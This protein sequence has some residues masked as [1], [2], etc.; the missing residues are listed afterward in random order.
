VLDEMR[1]SALIFVFEH[2]T[3]VNDEPKFGAAPGLSVLSDVVAQA[4]RERADGDERIDWNRLTE[5]GI[6]N[7][8]DGAWLLRARQAYG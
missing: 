8:G 2:G 4:I 7:T 1:K 5:R 6:L 3:G